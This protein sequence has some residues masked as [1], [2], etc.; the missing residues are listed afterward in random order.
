MTASHIQHVSTIIS[1]KWICPVRPINTTLE[2]Y[3]IIIDQDRIV[4]IIETKNVASLYE[5]DQHYQLHQ[6]YCHARSYQCAYACCYE[7]I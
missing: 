4:D 7:F 5:T 2:D 3:S 1:A 6:S